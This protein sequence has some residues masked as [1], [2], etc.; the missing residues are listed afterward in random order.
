MKIAILGGGS[1]GLALASHFINKNE[2]SIWEFFEDKALEMEKT[3]L[4]PYLKGARLDDRI[5]I[6]SDIDKVI[7][8]RDIIL[9]VVPSDKIVSTLEKCKNVGQKQTFIICS[10]GFT[11]D[12]QLLSDSAKK[13]ISNDIY[14]LYGPTIAEE[15]YH[16]QFTGMV[17]AG[18]KK[19][20]DIKE[21]LEDENLIIELSDDIVGVQ[22]GA[23]LKNILAM[24]IGMLDGLGQGE[25]AKSYFITKGLSEIIKLGLT[26]GAKEETFYGLAGIGDII[27]TCFSEKS[28]NRTFGQLIGEGKTMEQALSEMNNIVE[29]LAALKA[30]NQIS[31][32]KGIDLPVLNGLYK[33][34]FE[35]E[36]PMSFLNIQNKD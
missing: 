34:V 20:I 18:P 28:R 15:V 4:S 16:N 36:E 11:T 26:F 12:L 21:A 14:C 5:S 22:I 17:L 9:M 3:R 6:S 23:A 31:K 13:I 25:N 33:I 32:Q 8:N 1:W 27:T 2:V 7:L 10:K 35:N 24:S 30:L 19:N 29:G